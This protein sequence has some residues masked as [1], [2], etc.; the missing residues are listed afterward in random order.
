MQY[1]VAAEQRPAVKTL[2]LQ[3][4]QTT[5]ILFHENEVRLVTLF[6]G[7]IPHPF[8]VEQRISCTLLRWGVFLLLLHVYSCHTDL[9]QGWPTHNRDI[10][11]RSSECCHMC[12]QPAESQ[13]MTGGASGG[14]GGASGGGGEASPATTTT[15][16]GYE[17]DDGV[18]VEKPDELTLTEIST[19]LKVAIRR[20]PCPCG[21]SP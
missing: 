10:Q 4:A 11:V 15:C 7:F 1:Q 21:G 6:R 5:V 19:M 8:M 16:Y 13:R 3:L 2:S 14:G 18:C 9:F 12:A 20:P 17:D